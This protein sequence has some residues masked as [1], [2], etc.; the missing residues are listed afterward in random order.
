MIQVNLVII[1]DSLITKSLENRLLSIICDESIHVKLNC[2]ESSDL[3]K[4]QT[5]LTFISAV[6]QAKHFS[7]QY[8]VA[9][10]YCQL[11]NS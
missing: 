8:H 10:A 5:T 11:C 1:V 9:Q 2:N 3:Q 4:P 6:E 7:F